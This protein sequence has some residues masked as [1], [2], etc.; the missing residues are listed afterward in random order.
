MLLGIF[1]FIFILR[2]KLAHTDADRQGAA[3]D[4][5]S[6]VSRFVDSS[7]GIVVRKA[8]TQ[9]TQSI[10]EFNVTPWSHRS[11]ITKA[12]FCKQFLFCSSFFAIAV[13]TVK[14][15]EKQMRIFARKKQCIRLRFASPK[16][17]WLSRI[18]L[19]MFAG[20]RRANVNQSTSERTT[21]KI[22]CATYHVCVCDLWLNSKSFE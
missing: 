14:F 7:V 8:W 4:R 19:S 3:T 21:A 16:R 22:W 6:C 10:Y 5:F 18:R 11:P 20:I 17:K 1:I 9:N 13:E 12:Y 2:Y 15:R